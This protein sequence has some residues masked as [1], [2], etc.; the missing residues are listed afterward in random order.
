MGICTAARESSKTAKGGGKREY[1]K[2]QDKISGE[3][4]D[5]KAASAVIETKNDDQPEKDHNSYDK[6]EPEQLRSDK[7]IRKAEATLHKEP[8]LEVKDEAP[9]TLKPKI[10]YFRKEYGDLK[11]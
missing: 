9:K 1:P 8:S 6:G 7:N 2:L 5:S 11:S 3:C 4:K 10:L